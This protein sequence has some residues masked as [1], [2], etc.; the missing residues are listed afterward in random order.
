MLDYSFVRNHFV[1]FA[2]FDFEIFKKM[3]DAILRLSTLLE[4]KY[5]QYEKEEQLDQLLIE[6]DGENYEK[7][8]K[9]TKEWIDELILERSRGVNK[10]VSQAYSLLISSLTRATLEDLAENLREKY[11]NILQ[12]CNEK[13]RKVEG[14]QDHLETLRQRENDVRQRERLN[15]E[16]M[17]SPDSENPSFITITINHANSLP[18]MDPGGKRYD[19]LYILHFFYCLCVFIIATVKTVIK[20]QF[21]MISFFFF[22]LVIHMSKYF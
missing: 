2:S 13:K 11:A 14:L 18:S 7:N 17:R 16:G 8:R 22:F 12:S 1:R 19:I 20:Y 21:I 10:S 6:L 5:S 3:V 15:E 4:P 9:V